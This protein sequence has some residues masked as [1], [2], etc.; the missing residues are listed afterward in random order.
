MGVPAFFAWLANK[1]P[2]ILRDVSSVRTA[3]AARATAA[4]AAAA[5]AVA[6]QADPSQV[7]PVA[8]TAAD[9][10]IPAPMTCAQRTP[11]V[12]AP[13]VAISGLC[14]PGP[15]GSSGEHATQHTPTEAA[16][17]HLAV[18]RQKL[19]T[20]RTVLPRARYLVDR[21]HPLAQHGAQG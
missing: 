19:R 8:A 10:A 5:A 9:D 2:E 18:G 20:G 3:A 1:Y 12:A 13:P 4:A 15:T 17:A 21:V 6:A 14:G 11:A 7:L 16:A